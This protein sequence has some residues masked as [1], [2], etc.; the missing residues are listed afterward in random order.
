M[1]KK[2]AM[3][4]A[5]AIANDDGIE[6]AVT[7]FPGEFET[8]ETGYHYCPEVARS[9]LCRHEKLIELI[10]PQSLS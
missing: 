5:Q 7:F 3:N 8:E 4:E 10:R 6:M 1:L 9:T 2:E